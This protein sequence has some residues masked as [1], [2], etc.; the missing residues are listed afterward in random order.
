M[1]I[2]KI[3]DSFDQA[4][5]DVFDGATIMVGGFG[6]IGSMPSC[7]LEAVD[8]RDVK[9]LTT[10][11]NAAG[12]GADVWKMLEAP[13]PED[14]DILIRNG[15]ISRAI[16]SAPVSALYVNN[17]EKL[18]RAGKIELEMVPQG[19]LAERV[20]AAKFGLGGVYV[21][22]GLGT[23]VEQGKE[24]KVIDGREYLLELAI[25]ADFAIIK[26]HKADRW[27]NL[28]FKGTSRTFNA[29]MAGAAKVTIAEVDKIVELG[30]LDPEVIVTP[31][32]YVDRVVVRPEVAPDQGAEI[33]DEQA[34][35]SYA[36]FQADV[37][38]ATEKGGAK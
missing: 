19:T 38:R 1:A 23:V 35:E 5:A 24:K 26:A 4:V 9:N 36:K 6:T 34:K 11:S 14:M 18:L 28:V 17:F 31:G 21:P 15:R 29:T 7:L 32:I 12:F 16:I 27:G 13:F 20:R 30:E 10:I 2:N 22:V 37:K 25:K 33:Q 8:R 3:V